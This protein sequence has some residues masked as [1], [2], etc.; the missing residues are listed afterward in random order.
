MFL[1]ILSVLSFLLKFFLSYSFNLSLYL[2][3]CTGR[4]YFF[5]FFRSIYMLFAHYKVGPV[6]NKRKQIEK[7]IYCEIINLYFFNSND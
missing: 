1:I 3:T 7:A 5:L 2:G 4:Y 6:L